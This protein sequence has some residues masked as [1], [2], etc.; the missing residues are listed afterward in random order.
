METFDSSSRIILCNMTLQMNRRLVILNRSS[1]IFYTLLAIII[2]WNFTFRITFT[3]LVV[4]RV[5]RKAKE[6]HYC[7]YYQKN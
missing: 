1:E 2:I 4:P 6:V 3:E 7:S 5:V